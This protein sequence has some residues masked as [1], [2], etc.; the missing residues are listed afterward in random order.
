MQAG[1]QRQRQMQADKPT[2]IQREREVQKERLT[3]SDRDR[4]RYT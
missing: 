3:P 1:L 4:Q 2:Y